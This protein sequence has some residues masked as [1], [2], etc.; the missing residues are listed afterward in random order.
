MLAPSPVQLSLSNI[1]G[2]GVTAVGMRW[3]GNLSR[4][5]RPGVEIAAGLEQARLAVLGVFGLA[6]ASSDVSGDPL[7]LSSLGLDSLAFQKLLPCSKE[8]AHD[9]W[10]DSPFEGTQVRDMR[11]ATCSRTPDLSFALHLDHASIEIL[12]I[13]PMRTG[14]QCLLPGKYMSWQVHANPIYAYSYNCV[15]PRDESCDQTP[16]AAYLA[17]SPEFKAAV[18]MTTCCQLTGS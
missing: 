14:E 6:N 8:T 17:P 11:P 12:K 18:R 13:C 5:A 9:P 10:C 7:K 1:S 4:A 16:G 2:G 15:D 3:G